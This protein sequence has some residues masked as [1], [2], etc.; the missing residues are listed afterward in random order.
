[1]KMP[2]LAIPLTDIQAKKAKTKGKTY[3]LADGG[4]MYLEI[5]PTGSKIWRMFFRQANGKTN[6][7]T[8]GPYPLVSLQEA[9]N[10]RDAARKLMVQ[11]IDPAAEKK[12]LKLA[13]KAA[14]ANS[15]QVVGDEWFTTKILPL[16]EVHSNRV[17][18]YLRRYLYP[19]IGRRVMADIKAPELLECLRKI[20]ARKNN[21]GEQITETANRVRALMSNLWRYAIATGRCE[22]DIAADLKGSLKKHV[23]K[24][25]AHITDPQLLGKLLR[26]I[27]GYIGTPAVKAALQM[28]PLVFTR[29]GELRLA[30]WTDINFE[31]SE[32]RYMVSK[33]KMPHI[34]PLA[35]QTIAILQTLKPITGNSEYIFVAGRG[36]PISEASINNALR[37]LGWGGDVIV[38]HG[39]RH[40]ASTMLA[41]LGFDETEIERQLSHLVPG[42]KGKYQKAKYLESRRTMMTAWANYLDGLRVGASVVPIKK[43]K[44]AAA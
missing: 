36:K 39:F 33:T 40:T 2:K 23:E 31:E 29:P 8:F 16:S 12:R 20:E 1:M 34:V 41:E 5:A 44:K 28:L 6:R 3:T 10:Q 9:R 17:S 4:G 13:A 30:K 11:A 22:H 26:D 32:W 43:R 24:N 7:L 27:D 15:F 35:P 42:T 25:F 38:G 14:A 37:A 19:F 21:Q 18:S